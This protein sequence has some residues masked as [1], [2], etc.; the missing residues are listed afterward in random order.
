[1][2]L[3]IVQEKHL[4]LP[5]IE[6]AEQRLEIALHSRLFTR[7]RWQLRRL[8]LI[9]RF[10][11]HDLLPPALVDEPIADR[12]EKHRSRLHTPVAPAQVQ[13][14]FLHEVLRILGVMRQR[15]GIP[16]PHLK[17]FGVGRFRI[18]SWWLQAK[19]LSTRAPLNRQCSTARRDDAAI[20][21]PARS[22]NPPQASSHF[23]TSRTFLATLIGTTAGTLAVTRLLNFSP[24]NTFMPTTDAQVTVRLLDSTGA[25]TEPLTVHKVVKSDAGWRAQ[26]TSEQFRV[27]RTE[28]TERAFCGIFHDNHKN[29]FYSCVGCGLPLFRSD[30]KF[31]SGT[32]WPSFFQPVAAENIGSTVD[33]SY[34]MTRTEI[35]CVRCDSHLGHV[36]DDGPA[37]SGLRYCMNSAS[38]NFHE[39]GAKPA[40]EKII[41]GAGCFWGVESTFSKIKGVTS[42]RVGYAGGVTTKPTYEDVCSHNTGHAE[43]V[44]VEY[45]PAQI[46]LDALLD[47][48][49]TS[50]NPT[51]GRK[52]NA[53]SGSQYRSAIFFTIPAQEAAVRASAAK[54]EASGKFSG[55]IQTEILLA[56][57]FHVAEEYHQKYHEKQGGVCRT[58]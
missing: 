23:M 43:V 1:M 46:S 45:D 6:H 49:W 10:E 35:H 4:A 31:D 8:V 44:E 26:L 36:F 3:M 38:L 14:C 28:G 37:P 34:G 17:Q 25:L 21:R 19:N 54:W 24:R 57:P 12:C 18:L 56:P 50:H 7:E 53:D 55:P 41:L 13:P 20:K 16:V 33:S 11:R 15:Q 30:A 51:G 22:L 42:T 27:T 5:G 40:R 29:G 32:G 52:L 39:N 2:P 48:F 47:V 58:L 9:K